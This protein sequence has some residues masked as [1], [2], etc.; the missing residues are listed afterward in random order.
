MS[1]LQSR[2]PK[3]VVSAS[4][5]TGTEH[6]RRVGPV[7]SKSRTEGAHVEVIRDY[8]QVEQIRSIWTVWQRHPNA[9]IDFYLT[10][11]RSGR[12]MIRPHIL[13]LYRDGQPQTMLIGRLEQGHVIVRFGYRTIM[14][15]RAQMMTFIHGG[16]LGKPSREDAETLIREVCQSLHHGEADLAFLS[17]LNA[18][19]DLFRSAKSFSGLLTRDY[20]SV[21]DA[22]RSIALPGSSEELYRR[23]SSAVA[24]P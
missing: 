23:L 5:Q 13:V 19:S 24:A 4:T 3:I 18:E 11:L 15:L 9:D 17:H 22:H 20:V 7:A 21:I 10:V 2:Y 1:S 16:L 14:R 8:E 12:E 6:L